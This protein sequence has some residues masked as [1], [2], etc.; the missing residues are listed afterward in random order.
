MKTRSLRLRLLGFGAIA[1]LVALAA[2]WFSLTYL[3]ERHLERRV[4][5]ELERDAV[6]LIAGLR[7]EGGRA[8][9]DT[10]PSDPRFE[11]PSSGLYWQVSTPAG[12][13][14]SRSLWDQALPAST[15]TAG[16]DWSQRT[17]GGP[18]DQRVLLLERR[19]HF[20]DVPGGV[21]IQFASN[22]EPVKIARAEFGHESALFL[23]LLWLVLTAAAW[24]QVELG[25]RPLGRLK[26]ALESLRRDPAARLDV[27]DH[28]DEVAPLTQAI[29]DLAQAREKDLE[30][31]RRRSADL[32]HGLKTPL[33]ALT[34]Q[35]RRARGLGF[36]VTAD[37]F[38]QTIAALAAAVEGELARARA[39]AAR[40]AAADAHAPIKKVVEQLID[41][42]ERTDVGARVVF[43][44]RIAPGLE[45]M[46]SPG[47]LAEICGALIENAGR[48]ARRRVLVRGEG[49]PAGLRLYVEDDG[50]GIEERR[51]EEA[52]MRGGRLDEAGP[53]HGLGLSIARDLV[54]ATG[55]TV[56][57]GRSELGGLKVTLSWST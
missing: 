44:A 5:G 20:G 41:V 55:G 40:E 27:R 29:N 11:L 56:A 16:G 50:P 2:S 6:Q 14:R 47:D 43:E 39:A 1:V 32:A 42:M 53:G 24:L 13:V 21:L 12:V 54:E 9:V 37:D 49:G 57:L 7:T 15:V 23:G 48:F 36:E 33:A 17:T 4:A 10:S 26:S 25:L 28:P 31:A 19:L 35:S 34:A 18:F 3:F 8:L 45:A 52:L 30:R 46:V 22:E 51:M 38:D